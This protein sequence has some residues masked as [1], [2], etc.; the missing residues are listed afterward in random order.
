LRAED[1]RDIPLHTWLPEGEPDAV[2]QVLHG[3]GEHAGRYAR[4]AAAATGAN[5]AVVAHDHRGHGRHPAVR[6]HFADRHGWDLVL[7]DVL[8]VNGRIAA[9]FP[10]R[11][12]ILL[13]HSMGSFIAQAFLMRHPGQADRLIL[14]GS[15][16]GKRG[17]MHM[18]HALAAVLSAFGGRRRSAL[19]DALGFGAFNR[20]FRP[21]RTDYDWLSR[22]EAEVDRYL[23]DPLCGGRFTNRLWHDLTGG[24]L[25]ITSAIAVGRIPA[26]LPVLIVGGQRDPVGGER[27]LEKLAAVYRETGH[28]DVTLRVYPDA[29]HEMLN[30][31]NRDAVTTDVLCWIRSKL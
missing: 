24:L 17:E 30:E 4:F 31:I 18:A 7:G 16:F 3:L 5:L 2:V 29:R 20:P 26:E 23:A 13:G 27:R 10:G 21:A 14:S 1:G 8:A 12:L 9:Q 22:D 11:P 15:S 19:L 25:E 6:G 28:G